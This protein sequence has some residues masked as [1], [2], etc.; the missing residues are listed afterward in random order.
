MCWQFRHHPESPELAY[1]SDPNVWLTLS[2][3][4]E[5]MNDV[6]TDFLVGDG[7]LSLTFDPI[8]PWG[9]P[10]A[11]CCSLVTY[12]WKVDLCEWLVLNDAGNVQA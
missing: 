10:V 6:V 5:W 2:V 4:L 3:S 7:N 1:V 9:I 8:R 12:H 11:A